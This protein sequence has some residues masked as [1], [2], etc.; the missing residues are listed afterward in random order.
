MKR[1]PA[2]YRGDPG[3][4]GDSLGGAGAGPPVCPQW[5]GSRRGPSPPDGAVTR[6]VSG[7]TSDALNAAMVPLIEPAQCNGRYV[8]NSLVTPA[9]VCAG[10]LRGSVDSCQVPAPRSPW[11]PPSPLR[12]REASMSLGHARGFIWMSEV[13]TERE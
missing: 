11:A 12:G 5:P 8:Y 9:M 10:Y 6:S 13:A 1:R 4:P 2:S 3:S 7:K